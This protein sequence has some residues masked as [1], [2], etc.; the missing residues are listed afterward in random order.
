VETNFLKHIDNK[1]L[2]YI[3]ISN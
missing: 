3:L 2:K 1:K